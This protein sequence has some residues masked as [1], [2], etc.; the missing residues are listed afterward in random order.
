MIEAERF[1]HPPEPRRPHHAADAVEHDARA[2]ADAMA[3]ERGGKLGDRRHHEAEPRGLVGELALQ[4]EEVGAR[5]MRRLEAAAAGH[6]DIGIVAAGRGRLQISRAVIDPQVRAAEVA[7]Q[8]VGAYQGVGFAHRGLLWVRRDVRSRGGHSTTA[9]SLDRISFG[10]GNAMFRFRARIG[11][12]SLMNTKLA[13]VILAIGIAL[14]SC[15]GDDTTTAPAPPA[16]APPPAAAP[17]PAL[18]GLG[19]G[20]PLSRF[21]G[22]FQVNRI[23]CRQ[24]LAA[25]GRDRDAATIFFYGYLAARAGIKDSDTS[26]ADAD[27]HRVLDQC[28]RSPDLTVTN[29]FRQTLST[30]AHWFWQTP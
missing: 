1:Q 6:R 18:P 24:L 28:S 11:A 20:A 21:G 27:L 23:T 19:L 30:P 29:A 15:A 13:A 9:F 2:L 16:V 10:D 17:M 5:D 7:R 22:V 12:E 3:A 4:V 26:N 8:G 25:R 14:A